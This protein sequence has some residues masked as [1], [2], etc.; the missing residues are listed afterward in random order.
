[1]CEKLFGA[2]LP[3]R[4]C[5]FQQFIKNLLQSCEGTAAYMHDIIF[6]RKT[7]DEHA[8]NIEQVLDRLEKSCLT[9]RKDKC[10]FMA[11]SENLGFIVNN[12]A[13]QISSEKTK[14]VL[15]MPRPVNFT[16]LRSF[17]G[18]V[19]HYSKFFPNLFGRCAVFHKLIKKNKWDW[20]AKCEKQFQELKSRL[21]EATYLV[22]FNPLLPLIL[23]AD[24]LHFG[25]EAVLSHRCP[26]GSKKPCSG[27]Q[28]PLTG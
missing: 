25:I 22:H 13:E 9:I 28:N 10:S 17:L 12:N 20:T 24:A 18:M 15:E 2:S 8:R 19:N 5:L 14:A 23:A 1:M 21:I 7:N 6:T 3:E 4:K 11:K 27:F 16:H 26:G